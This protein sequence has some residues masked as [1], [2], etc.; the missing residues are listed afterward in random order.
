MNGVLD[1]RPSDHY[2]SNAR[3]PPAFV[4]RCKSQRMPAKEESNFRANPHRFQR[5]SL[6]ASNVPQADGSDLN[7]ARPK[8][9]QHRA[10]LPAHRR[11]ALRTMLTVL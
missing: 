11:Q 4:G 8:Q 7:I 1:R 9:A 3:S 6:C 5:T 10:A 2:Q